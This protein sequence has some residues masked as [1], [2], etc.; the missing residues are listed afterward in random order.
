MTHKTN[1]ISHRL[2]IFENWRSRYFKRKDLGFLLEEDHLIRDLIDKKFKRSGIERIE[3]ERSGQE[4]KLFIFSARPGFII[5]R[6]GTGIND[7]RQELEKNISKLRQKNNYSQDFVLQISVEEV[8]KP[9]ISA[10][11]VSENIA[12]ALEKRAP[13]RRV[14]KST[15]SKIM[16]YKEVKGAKILVSGR[17]GGVEISRTEWL[18]DGKIP[19]ITLRSK[20]DYTE[21]RAYC[22]YGVLGIKVWIYKGEQT[23]FDETKK[24]EI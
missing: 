18:S 20:I 3:I 4:V 19:L 22:S 16:S 17:L 23:D 7:L 5:G 11:I 15:L 9:E 24:L 13:F 12:L 21:N 2:G 6:G 14:M 1:P 8:K 10:R